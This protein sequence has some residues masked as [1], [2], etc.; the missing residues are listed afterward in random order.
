MAKHEEYMDTREPYIGDKIG[1]DEWMLDVLDKEDVVYETGIP[2][3]E[4]TDEL[5]REIAIFISDDDEY[6]TSFWHAIKR[7]YENEYT[8]AQAITTK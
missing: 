8:P 7:W 2:E 4:L 1:H 3:D 6:R 5:M